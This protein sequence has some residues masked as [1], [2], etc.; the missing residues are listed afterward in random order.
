MFDINRFRNNKASDLRYQTQLNRMKQT[1]HDTSFIETAVNGSL[2]NLNNS[3]NSFVIYGE[4]QSGKT[5][6]MICLTAKLLDTGKKIIIVLL[7]DNVELLKQNLRRFKK[8]GIAPDPKNFTEIIDPTV[9]I[10]DN[11]WIIFCKK[12]ANDLR[13]LIEKLRVISQTVILDDEAD[14]ASPNAKKSQG[15][16]STIN[17]LVGK[18]LGTNGIYIG[19]TATPARLDLNNTFDNANDRWVDF[20]PHGSYTGQDVFFPINLDSELNY[21]PP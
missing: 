11:E 2:G 6:M 7:N 20:P 3:V 9:E 5:E 1:G 18:L 15:S 21:P 16:I 14:Y 13:K 4:P 10:G 8:S 12:N 19:V 17:D